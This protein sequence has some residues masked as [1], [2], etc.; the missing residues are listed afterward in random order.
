MATAA[1]K[2]R[3]KAAR[4]AARQQAGHDDQAADEQAPPAAPAR[5]QRSDLVRINVDL[6]PALHE[7][8]D[9]WAL[10]QTRR[11]RAGRT[12]R[13]DV[14]RLLIRRI[15]RDEQLQAE[16]LDEVMRERRKA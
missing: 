16:I 9:D 11:L 3:E 2:A 15:L 1:E 5:A 4:L 8:F 14:Q 6:P 13:Q 10:K 7:Q 12:I